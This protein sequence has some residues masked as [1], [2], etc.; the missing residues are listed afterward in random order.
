MLATLQTDN[1]HTR[2]AS[3]SS[4]AAMQ[5]AFSLGADALPTPPATM[6]TPPN[7]LPAHIDASA[8][9]KRKRT[10]SEEPRLQ[11]ASKRPRV[12][13]DA[14]KTATNN[15]R[16]SARSTPIPTIGRKHKVA[17]HVVPPVPPPVRVNVIQRPC[18]ANADGT[19]E[20]LVSCFDIVQRNVNNFKQCMSTCFLSHCSFLSARHN[21]LLIQLNLAFFDF[22]RVVFTNPGDFNDQSWTPEYL[23]FVWLEYPNTG[24]RERLVTLWCSGLRW[25]GSSSHR[26]LLL[27][28]KD[29]DHWHPIRQ[30]IDT[31][32]LI[33]HCRSAS[34]PNNEAFLTCPPQ[35][36]FRRTWFPTHSAI[37]IHS[38]SPV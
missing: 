24:A 9:K 33:A 12:S 38:P 8:T 14:T 27:E 23:P 31:V 13:D 21:A 32:K 7:Q 6:P 5:S 34:N 37:P 15:S 19:V 10:D 25:P 30:L 35:G 2:D 36:T 17:L 28:P 22:G 4:S 20:N 18:T 3:C 11:L 26:Y 16:G 29:P 1:P